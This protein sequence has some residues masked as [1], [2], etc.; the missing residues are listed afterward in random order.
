MRTINWH[1]GLGDAIVCAPIAMK[2]ASRGYVMATAGNFISVDSIFS[3]TDVGVHVVK[4]AYPVED[5]IL[6]LGH[7]GIKRAEGESFDRWFF[8]QAGMNI[9]DRSLCPITNYHWRGVEQYPIPGNPGEYIFI[10]EDTGRG[11]YID[12]NKIWGRIDKITPYKTDG[13]I[14]SYCEIL[15]NAAEVHVIDSAFLHLADRLP[16]TGKLFWHR[17]SRANE[18]T[19]GL[20]LEKNWTIYGA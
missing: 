5:A 4:D 16:C 3:A 10:H 19:K 2:Y 17:Y 6:N 15:I 1:L 18:D 11:F 8:R 20:Y 13:S 7:Y 9:K 14:L 12:H